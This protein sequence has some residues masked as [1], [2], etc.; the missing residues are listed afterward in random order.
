M[1]RLLIG[2][3]GS[4]KSHWIADRLEALTAAGQE[5][6]FLLVP[7]QSS[8]ENERALLQRLG[9]RRAAGVQ[10]LSFTRLADTVFREVGGLC[11]AAPDEGTQA[12][13]MSQALERAAA[14]A[15]DCGEPLLGVSPRQITDAAYVQQLV[16]LREELRQCAVPVEELEK[17]S[18][19]LTAAG[20]NSLPQ[21]TRDLY[22]IFAAYDGSSIGDGA[23]ALTRLA[24]K[25]PDSRLPDGA[26]VLVDGFKGFTAQEL[27][28]LERLLPRVA[29]LT[30]AL[31]SDT[32]GRCLHSHTDTAREYTLF[33][34]VTDTVQ[35]LCRLAEPH[36]LTWQ[37][38]LLTENRRSTGALAALEAGLYAPSPAVY[39]RP[40]EAVTVTPCTDTYEA[41][42]YVARS[43]RR[44]LRQEGYRCR[45]ITVVARNLTEYQGLLEDA[46]AQEEIP[47]FTDARQELLCE[48]L[49]VYVRSALRLAV[50]GWRTE[51]LLRLL[52][53]DLTPLSPVETARLENYVYL[54][55]I[56]GDDWTSPFTENP[57]GLTAGVTAQTGRELS[58][59]N[60]W[61]EGL[62]AP[63]TTLRQALRGTLNGRQ[64][65]MALYRYLTADEALPERIARQTARLEEL[66][67]PLLAAHAA[68]LWDELIGILDR[69]ADVLGDQPMPAARLEE[70]FGMLV[71][72]IDMGQIPQGLDAVTIGSAD[73]IRYTNPRAV[74]ILGANEGVF[75]AYPEEGGLLSE[76]DR[77]LWEQQGVCLSGDTLSRCI[78]E[79]YYAYAAVAAPSERLTVT[80]LTGGDAAPS[81]LVEQI[82]RILPAHT[83]GMAAAPDGSDIESAEE[84]FQ[85]LAETAACPN[86]LHAGLQAV[87]AGQPAFAG[88]LAA[89]QRSAGQAPFRLEQP[90][91]TAELFGSDMCLS[92]SQ[93]EKFYDCHF[94]YFCRY[95]LHIQ[96]RRPARVD[97]AAF[98]TVVHYVMETLLPV[99]V[100]CGGEGGLIARLK[101]DDEAMA[102]R[103]E[104]EKAAA[105]NALQAELMTR[106]RGDVHRVVTA[107][108]EEQ[109]GGSERRS[110]RFLYQLQLTERAA[111][112]MLWHTIMELRQSLFTPRDYELSILPD[113]DSGRDGVLSVRLPYSGGQLRL[114]GKVD[115][116][117]LYIRF[118]GQ[119]FVRVVDYKTGSKTFD[120]SEL[121]AG[122]NTQML[123]YLFIICDNSRRY[124]EGSGQLHPAGVLYHPLSDTVVERSTPDARQA[125][126]RSM[127]MSG[128]VL[129][130][131]AVI[132][133][134][135]EHAESVFI[136]AKLDKA[137]APKGNVITP[138][139]FAL[140]RGVVEQLLRN[141][142]EQLA[143]GDIAALPLINENHD[144]CRYCDYRVV[145][146]REDED[147]ARPLC[148]RSMATVLEEL[149]AAEDAQEVTENG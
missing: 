118:D 10:V 117:D 29:E 36:G 38:E 93:T 23:D 111:C 67:E 105:E 24:D 51:E 136:P 68:R 40:A 62:I 56:E 21:R 147:P 43:I 146:C 102:G 15:A 45:E 114:T 14:V 12:L 55:G 104:A 96:P 65:A 85:R 73:R 80:Y 115:R 54:W 78:E 144:P 108:V 77:R 71:Q 17:L 99:Y 132:H 5:K 84:A 11:G 101:D 52:K 66:A 25:L 47:C 63:L 61:R 70:L 6:L 1:L 113:P 22:R 131:P 33:S 42:A 91:I 143:A 64:F 46:L 81:P 145:C 74:F 134:M 142:A 86:T 79:R 19:A 58:L 133:A 75:P 4:G 107:F 72:M 83:R 97:A 127:C 82:R 34:P 59:L 28:V 109:M 121:T 49:V 88:R 27:R 94:A 37:I 44:L 140:L 92:A 60:T 18:Q 95:G 122:L 116:V 137:G 35:Q 130:D 135:E 32:P 57:A 69:F 124:L 120:L 89:V 31:G 110:G 41:C 3:S 106:L 103:N 129:D 98:G 76:D 119:A 141:M 123:L 148:S 112:N 138:R 125:R 16:A 87:L 139:Q 26:T 7:E 20:A 128:L 30:I 13:R 8:F 48:P 50:G 2:R 39:D 126:L 53:T 90:G 149:E 9:T 100:G